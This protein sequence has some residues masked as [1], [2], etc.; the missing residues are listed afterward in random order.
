MIRI[1]L[2]GASQIAPGAVIGPASKIDD[3]S[4]VAV[5][6]SRR[7]KAK[8]FALEHGIAETADGYAAL[9]EVPEIDIIYNALPP[10]AHEVWSVA[11]LK[12][13]KHVLCEKPFAMNAVQ[14]RRMVEAAQETGRHLVEAI[15]YRF[16]PYFHRALELL[17][18]GTIGEIRHITATFE[19]RIPFS[20]TEFRHLPEL[21]GGALMDLGCYS[22]HW[23]RT[24]LGSEPRVISAECVM[25]GSGVDLA[26]RAQLEFPR[27]VTADISCSMEEH[28][29]GKHI[30]RAVIEGENGRVTLENPLA[31]HKGN[32]IVVEDADG[33]REEYFSGESTYFHQLQHFLAVLNGTATPLTGGDDAVNN[34]QLIDDIYR[35][36]GVP[37][38]GLG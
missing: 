17:R 2:L 6:A 14:A 3:V 11:A 23:V 15:H 16:H 24:I 10:S 8:G 35:A 27:K 7:E 37:L 30:S 22:V 29:S 4:V 38:R 9:V 13:G 20:D 28:L 31:P 36:A 12:A 19:V 25:G 18:S 1:G 33:S 26:T 34:I 21:G 5:A 32:K